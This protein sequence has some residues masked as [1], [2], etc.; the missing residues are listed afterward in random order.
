MLDPSSLNKTNILT[1]LTAMITSM[2]W[3]L[4]FLLEM[5]VIYVIVSVKPL[6]GDVK[7]QI[8][9][10]VSVGDDCIYLGHYLLFDYG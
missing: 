7:S 10:T 5:W 4:E 8:A 6:L 1:A 3:C 2:L 9:N